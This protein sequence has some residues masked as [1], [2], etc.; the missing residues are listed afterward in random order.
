MA[1]EASRLAFDSEVKGDAR[2]IQLLHNLVKRGS[3]HAK[4]LRQVHAH[5]YVD[6]PRY[7]WQEFATYRVGVEVCSQST[8]HTILKREL[9]SHDF[10]GGMD[11]ATIS[12]LNR[13]RER[14]DWYSL[15]Q[16]L[17]ESFKQARYI[18]A[19]YQALRA[20]YLDRRKH[21]LPE[22]RLYCEWIEGLPYADALITFLGE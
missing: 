8:M 18:D 13:R 22:W 3:S 6:A 11:D 16:M 20:I 17:P 14:G 4:S 7:F 10:E 15:K 19:S 1:V 12:I 9:C 2:D 21:R 5:H